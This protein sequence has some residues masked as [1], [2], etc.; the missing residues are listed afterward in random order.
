MIINHSIIPDTYKCGK[1][2]MRYLVASGVPIMSY[3][4][5]YFYFT[6]TELLQNFLKTMPLHLKILAGLSGKKGGK[7]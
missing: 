7:M 4:E 3:D 5:Q 1:A 2:V 6:N